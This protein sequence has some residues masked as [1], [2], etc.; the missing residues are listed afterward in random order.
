MLQ[1]TLRGA[2]MP[3]RRITPA[4]TLNGAWKR[5]FNSGAESRPTTQLRL[6]GRTSP[7]NSTLLRTRKL[8][9]PSF[10]N[11]VGNTCRGTTRRGFRFSARQRSSQGTA[12]EEP[13][14]LGAK[15]KRLSKEY[16]WAAVG[17][18]FGLSVLDFPFCFLLVR[19]VGAEAIGG[20]FPSL[21]VT[22]IIPEPVRRQTSE[23]VSS[24]WNAIRKK[25]VKETGKENATDAVEM[26]TW[27]V[28]EAE[29][30]NREGP[31]L[32]TQLALAYAIH[33]SLIFFRVPLAAAVT[34]KV[35]KVLRGWGWNIGKKVPPRAS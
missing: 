13:Q 30:H 35:V 3:F 8:S 10:A 18:Y 24:V 4:G 19:T 7:L 22:A 6:G 31:S 9:Q 21:D 20:I 2:S 28:K 33:K 15:L 29:E 16:G 12:G 23:L 25:E 26:A 1:S 32:A 11:T 5:L 34:P 27:D 14:S 17:V